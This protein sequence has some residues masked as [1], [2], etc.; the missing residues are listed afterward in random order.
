MYL[1]SGQKYAITSASVEDG[2]VTVWCLSTRT[3]GISAVC[4][5]YY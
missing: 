5:N 2:L 4:C 3:S 1:Y